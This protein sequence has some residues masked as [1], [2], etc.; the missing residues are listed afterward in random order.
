MATTW[1]KEVFPGGPSIWSSDYF[2]WQAT[3]PWQYGVG[4]TTWTLQPNLS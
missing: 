3:L 4:T 1:T 2:P